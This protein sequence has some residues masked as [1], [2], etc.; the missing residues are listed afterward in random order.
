MRDFAFK[1]CLFSYIFLFWTTRD[2]HKNKWLDTVFYGD[3]HICSVDYCYVYWSC[4]NFHRL[5]SVGS[6]DDDSLEDGEE[7]EEEEDS[8]EEEDS[9]ADSSDDEGWEGEMPP[10]TVEQEQLLESAL[11]SF[12]FLPRTCVDKVSITYPRFFRNLQE[13]AGLL[14]SCRCWWSCGGRGAAGA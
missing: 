2:K 1:L 8:A 9:D 7:L 12:T 5:H 11:A 10:W 6:E 4:N 13:D 14:S 3:G